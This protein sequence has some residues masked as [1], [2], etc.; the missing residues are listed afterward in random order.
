MEPAARR[1]T[2]ATYAARMQLAPH[3]PTPRPS[4]V[5]APIERLPRNLPAV[6]FVPRGTTEHDA[7]ERW[8]DWNLAT[9]TWPAGF[10]RTTGAPVT[11]S[12]RVVLAPYDEFRDAV[13]L[14][15]RTRFDQVV[16]IAH[17]RSGFERTNAVGGPQAI[18]QARDGA[19]YVAT[20]GYWESSDHIEPIN[21]DIFPAGATVRQH[22][23]DLK[24]I[25][26]RHTWVD[27]TSAGRD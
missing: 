12:Q 22:V 13:K 24:A 3:A 16:A 25:V 9:V 6:D 18:L 19:W 5:T 14:D 26:D 10:D 21:L 1:R 15:A 4:L 8:F 23:R 2:R 17:A 11:D 27:F 7:P 20:A